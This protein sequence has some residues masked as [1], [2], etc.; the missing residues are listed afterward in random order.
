MGKGNRKGKEDREKRKIIWTRGKEGGQKEKGE[1]KKGKRD[2]LVWKGEGSARGKWRRNRKEEKKGK[3]RTNRKEEKRERKEGQ[4][5]SGACSLCQQ[6][7][8]SRPYC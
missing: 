1:E 8:G 7:L 2:N 6:G 5:S 4:V 3:W